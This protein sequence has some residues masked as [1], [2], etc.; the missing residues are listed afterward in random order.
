MVAKRHRNYQFFPFCVWIFADQIGSLTKIALIFFLVPCFTSSPFSTPGT[1]ISFLLFTWVARCQA[2]RYIRS[3]QHWIFLI[4]VANWGFQKISITSINWWGNPESKRLED[5]KCEVANGTCR[6]LILDLKQ[7]FLV[8][9][10][11]KFPFVSIIT[12]RSKH[13]EASIPKSAFA[14]MLKQV[15][16]R[17]E[18]NA[19]LFV[20]WKWR[21][22]TWIHLSW[23]QNDGARSLY[24][25]GCSLYVLN[26][27]C[28]YKVWI[29]LSLPFSR[30]TLQHAYC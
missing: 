9:L 30:A 23:S 15:K 21:V 26:P 7:S 13:A 6:N 29:M 14:F 16:L 2:T 20:A 22:T 28:Y 11:I 27:R 4:S 12:G 24:F 19:Q 3:S 5:E 17:R 10:I 8:S 1:L 25:L 18:K